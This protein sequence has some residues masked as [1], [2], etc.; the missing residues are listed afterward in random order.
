M[1]LSQS[2]MN[3]TLCQNFHENDI[4]I[5]IQ[6]C[7]LDNLK[8]LDLKLQIKIACTSKIYLNRPSAEIQMDSYSNINFM[9]EVEF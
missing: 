2:D 7:K 4:L 1:I 3:F 8:Y 6:R 5:N 9:V